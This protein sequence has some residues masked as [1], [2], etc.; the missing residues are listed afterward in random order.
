MHFHDTYGMAVA[1]AFAAMQLGISIFDSSAGG[2][3]GC[4][5]APGA[6]GNV[7]TETLLHLFDNLKIATGVSLPRLQHAALYVKAAI[8]D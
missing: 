2:I 8:K 7:A 5:Y 4:P 6:S 3:G 1:N